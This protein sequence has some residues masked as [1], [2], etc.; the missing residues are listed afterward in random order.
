MSYSGVISDRTPKHF[1]RLWLEL[2]N[3]RL[4]GLWR[5]CSFIQ[6]NYNTIAYLFKDAVC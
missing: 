4:V 2:H 6:G 5:F 1:V 3:F